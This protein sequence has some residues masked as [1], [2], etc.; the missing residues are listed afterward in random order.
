MVQA[1]IPRRAA[2]AAFGAA[3]AAPAIAQGSRPVTVIVPFSPGAPPDLVG[4]LIAEGLARRTGQ[5]HVVD[6]RVG[7]SGNIGTAAAARAAADGTTLMITTNTLVMN[8]P[9]FRS[10]PYDPVASFAPV[11]ELGTIGFGLLLHPS[12]GASVAEFVARA[13]ARPGALNYGSPGIGT[14]QH[15]GMELLRQRAGIDVTHIPYRGFAGAT[16]DL[17]SGQVAALFSTIGAARELASGGRIHLV[18]V[19]SAARLPIVPEVP[20]FA[21]AGVGGL[22]MA[23]WYGLFVPAGAPQAIVARLNAAANEVLASPEISAAM[24]AQGITVT[25]GP[26]ERLRDLVAADLPRWT[27]MV[28]DAGIAPE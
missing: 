4:R 17:L 3:L 11:A 19:A 24:A 6:N 10:L 27:A 25:G 7:A 12:G 9:L 1:A 21:E 20:T 23:A 5:P 18:A 13:K 16:T 26:P 15:L 8:V 22:E 28:R 14:P 2:L